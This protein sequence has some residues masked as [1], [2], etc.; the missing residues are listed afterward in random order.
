MRDTMF[1]VLEIMSRRTSLPSN[2]H[3]AFEILNQEYDQFES[4]FRSFFDEMVAFVE[5]EFEVGISKPPN[6]LVLL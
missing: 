6:Q 1:H 4:L 2:S 3:W 5:L